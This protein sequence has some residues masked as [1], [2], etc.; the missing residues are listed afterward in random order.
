MEL[1]ILKEVRNI[2]ERRKI[3][4][5][6]EIKEKMSA[7]QLIKGIQVEIQCLDSSDNQFGGR[8]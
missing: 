4:H 1:N 7:K 6:Y 8:G 2:D 5:S 3:C